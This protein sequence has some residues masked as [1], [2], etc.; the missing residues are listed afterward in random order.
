MESFSDLLKVK[1]NFD[2]SHL[3]FP[4]IVEW[5]LAILLLAIVFVHGP[6]LFAQ[7]R[8]GVMR[9]RVARWQVDKRR[10]FGALLLTL[11]YFASMQPVGLIY[12][13]SGIGFLLTS[14]VYSFAL[15]WVFSRDLN[16][17]KWILIISSS[18]LTP[19]AVWLIFS[20]VFKITLP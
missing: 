5:L 17:R 3:F 7:L 2:Q 15:S 11:V 9:S 13:N 18:V 6:E 20:T 1:I 19:F 16:K 8:S 12:P 10:L 14:I 4:T